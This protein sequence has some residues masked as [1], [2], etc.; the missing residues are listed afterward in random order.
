[1]LGLHAS[2]VRCARAALLAACIA[3]GVAELS[4]VDD[5]S[6]HDHEFRPIPPEDDLILETS[7]EAPLSLQPR[8]PRELW[9]MHTETE[10]LTRISCTNSR[11]QSPCT[12]VGTSAVGDHDTLVT[13]RACDAELQDLRIVVI[14]TTSDAARVLTGFQSMSEPGTCVFPQVGPFGIPYM[15]R[16]KCS[17]GTRKDSAA[18]FARKLRR[19]GARTVQP[20]WQARQWLSGGGAQRN[21]S[22]V[23]SPVGMGPR[24]FS[25]LEQERSA[26][27]LTASA[28]PRQHAAV[29]LAAL[30]DGAELASLEFLNVPNH[31]GGSLDVVGSTEWR[32]LDRAA[33]TAASDRPSQ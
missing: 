21:E 28:F 15:R 25:R 29:R 23:D 20:Q 31:G 16:A 27:V 7:S 1:M 9:S 11:R 18:A 6:L 33:E 8:G 12:Y 14:N 30:T 10:R 2:A 24:L 5:C 3:R 4:I 13:L 32:F 19:P 17:S 26:T 22:G